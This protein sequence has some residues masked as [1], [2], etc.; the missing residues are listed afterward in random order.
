MWPPDP[1][2]GRWHQGY[3]RGGTSTSGSRGPR[4]SVILKSLGSVNPISI[5]LSSGTVEIYFLLHF[6]RFTKI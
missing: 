3:K 5:A 6:C 4:V 2:L 1:V